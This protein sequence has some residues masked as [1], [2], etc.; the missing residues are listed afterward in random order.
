MEFVH[1]LD[2]KPTRLIDLCDSADLSSL[3]F[4]IFVSNVIVPVRFSATTHTDLVLRAHERGVKV[5]TI[6]NA[7][8]MNAVGCCGLQVRIYSTFSN[9]F[10]LICDGLFMFFLQ[11][12]SFGETVSI[13][14][15][16]E[17][18]RPQSFFDKI[19][20]NKKLGFHTLCLLGAHQL[21]QQLIV[22]TALE[23]K[24]LKLKILLIFFRYQ[25]QRAD[26]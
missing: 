16:T 20:R 7:S 12:Y 6:H 11:L 5:K 21:T 24:R 15:W 9:M 23:N 26:D 4:Y 25:G 3:C 18:W 19:E 14:L 8:I 2:T 22:L 17:S 10:T 1:G 13:V